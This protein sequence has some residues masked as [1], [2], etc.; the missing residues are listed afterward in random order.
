MARTDARAGLGLEEALERCKEF[1]RLGADITFLEA[2]QTEEE[3]RRYCQEVD[4]PKLANMLEVHPAALDSHAHGD[5]AY[6][7]V[8]RCLCP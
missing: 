6:A 4:G 1:R 8:G 2:P 3:M 5:S 7:H